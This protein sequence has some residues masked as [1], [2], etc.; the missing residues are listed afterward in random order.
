MNATVCAR[1]GK[2]FWAFFQKFTYF[3][4][5]TPQ[6]TRLIYLFIWF[7]VRSFCATYTLCDIEFF[8]YIRCTLKQHPK[9]L[10]WKIFNGH[11]T[12]LRDNKSL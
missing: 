3:N 5:L 8:C 4:Q 10:F 2:H 9:T 12:F 1:K 7:T 6:Y 11:L